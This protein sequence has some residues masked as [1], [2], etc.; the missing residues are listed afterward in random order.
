MNN[1]LNI[2][3]FIF[4]NLQKR[5]INQNNL[6]TKFIYYIKTLKERWFKK[7]NSFVYVFQTFQFNE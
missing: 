5:I 1:N 3:V 7:Q 4:L 2:K 6:L